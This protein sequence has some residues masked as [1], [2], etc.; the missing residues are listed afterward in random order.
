[1]SVLS[2]GRYNEPQYLNCPLQKD[3]NMTLYDV[4]TLG[5]TMIRLTPPGQKR[6]ETAVTLD[7]EVGGSESNTAVGLARL[8]LRVAWLSRLTDNPLG[9][10]IA[11]TLRR[12]GVDTSHVVWTEGDRVGLYFLEEGD[13]PRGGQVFYDRRDSAV[14][15]MQPTDLPADLFR[16]D[17]ARLLH[18]TGITPALSQSL[19]ATALDAVQR[20]KAAGWLISF[21][22]NY[23]SK[24]WTTEAASAGCEPFLQQADIVF[25]PLRDAC[26]F[27]SLPT[28]ADQVLDTL[29]TRFQPSVAVLTLGAEG[30]AALDQTGARYR[31][32]AVQAGGV[33]RVGGGDAFTAGF[34]YGFLTSQPADALSAALRWGTAVAALKYTIP[35]DLPL[36]ERAEAARLVADEA[37]GKTGLIR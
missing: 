37:G 11:G 3:V 26:A 23:R 28:D 2:E 9:H 31:Q 17:G 1:M 20:A 14:S 18:V 21:D 13:A 27:W 12:F 8:G 6:L 35:G 10:L 5:E 33:G 25:A 34:L 36:I 32:G 29:M 7:V 16:P 30:A 19:A 24:L 4:V 22:L 15:K